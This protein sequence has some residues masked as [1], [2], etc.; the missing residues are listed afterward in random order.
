MYL[1]LKLKSPKLVSSINSSYTYFI[2]S[3]HAKNVS[4]NF[5]RSTNSP[6]YYIIKIDRCLSTK[7]C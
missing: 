2:I 6:L 3:F 7:L 5:R 1:Y 4:V